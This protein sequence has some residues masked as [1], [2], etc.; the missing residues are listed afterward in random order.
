MITFTLTGFSWEPLM[1]LKAVT[2]T[3]QITLDLALVDIYLNLY[4][5]HEV[6]YAWMLHGSLAK[7]A[8]VI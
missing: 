7:N 6:H 5:L 8:K 1:T 4:I 3:S 2:Y